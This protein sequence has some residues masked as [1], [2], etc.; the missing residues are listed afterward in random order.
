MASAGEVGDGLEGVIA[1]V[2]VD[3]REGAA[4]H[5]GLGEHLILGR[6]L[7]GEDAELPVR[8][9]WGAAGRCGRRRGSRRARAA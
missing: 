9:K 7:Q 5:G 4:W 1:G 8:G 2:I 3:H 6:L